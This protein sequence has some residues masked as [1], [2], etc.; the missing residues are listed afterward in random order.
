MH[1]AFEAACATLG[2]QPNAD[3]LLPACNMLVGDGWMLVL[4]RRQEHFQ[5]ISL[6]A[7]SFGGTIY[8]RDPAQMDAIRLAGPLRALASVGVPIDSENGGT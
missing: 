4:P 1:V 5:G 2:L 6:N 8:V 3:G 7:L